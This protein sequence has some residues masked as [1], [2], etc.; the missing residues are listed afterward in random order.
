MDAILQEIVTTVH[1]L[2]LLIYLYIQN[3][4]KYYINNEIELKI[5]STKKKK[6]LI[7]V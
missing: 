2:F 5:N 6:K 7:Y 1:N 4:L 3:V